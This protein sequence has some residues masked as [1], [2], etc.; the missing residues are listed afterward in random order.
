[1]SRGFRDNHKATAKDLLWLAL[2]VL[3]LGLIVGIALE[4]IK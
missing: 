1:M 2:F 3:V 4:V